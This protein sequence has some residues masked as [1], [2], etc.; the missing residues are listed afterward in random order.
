MEKAENLFDPLTD[1]SEDDGEPG[2]HKRKKKKKE[3]EKKVVVKKKKMIPDRNPKSIFSSAPEDHDE[4]HNERAETM[5]ETLMDEGQLRELR[6]AYLSHYY[7]N[8]KDFNNTKKKDK[9]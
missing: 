7:L 1:S 5:I 6:E 2:L 8:E 4:K 3:P 9:K